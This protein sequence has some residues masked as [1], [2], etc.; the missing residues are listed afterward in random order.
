MCAP[1]FVI[2]MSK[3]LYVVCCRGDAELFVVPCRTKAPLFR[4]FPAPT[5]PRAEEAA[6]SSGGEGE[7]GGGG[8]ASEA[9]ECYVEAVPE[10]SG[11]GSRVIITHRSLSHVCEVV[12]EDGHAVECGAVRDIVEIKDAVDGVVPELVDH[13]HEHGRGLLD[14]LVLDRQ[15]IAAALRR[16]RG[17]SPRASCPRR[18]RPSPR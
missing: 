6:E 9:P 15:V 18:P 2:T 17:G 13:G 7:G 4:S 16:R 5:S 3:L 14:V 1:A 10:T 12:L 11:G 8:K